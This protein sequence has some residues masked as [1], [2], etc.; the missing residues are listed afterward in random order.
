[1]VLRRGKF[2]IGEPFFNPGNLLA[3][4]RRGS[5]PVEVGELVLVEVSPDGNRGRIV[6]RLGSPMDVELQL[7]A[8]G[9]EAGVRRPFPAEALAEAGALPEDP[10]PPRGDR[11]D[12]RD[13]IAFTIDPGTAKDHDDALTIERDGDGYL[14]LVHIADVAAAVPLGSALDREARRRGCSVYLP[15][16]VEPMLPQALSAGLCSLVPG[17]PRDTLTVEL[18]FSAT[19]D[20]GTPR[21]GRGQISSARR[22]SYDEVELVLT[23][24]EQVPAALHRA[25]TDS[26]GSPRCC[27]TA[28]PRAVRC[29]W[30]RPSRSSTWAAVTCARPAWRRRRAPT[31]W[32][33]S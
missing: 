8:L 28:G 20:V 13:R 10:P 21:F 7:A 25:L 23:G 30:S 18:P 12:Y 5:V 11:R 26:T 19:G 22:F 15:G 1:M 27:A 14:V 24:H 4:G 3:L 9:A 2:L 33:R 6:E 16:R 31:R 29:C 32:S 17:R